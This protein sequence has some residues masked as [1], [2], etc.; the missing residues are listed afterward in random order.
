MYRSKSTQ[1]FGKCFCGFLV[2][3][4]WLTRRGESR[5]TI[6]GARGDKGRDEVGRSPAAVR[7]A[8]AGTRVVRARI[9]SPYL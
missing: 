1:T 2:K 8:A 9:T 4:Q 6:G 5:A 3:N 7:P